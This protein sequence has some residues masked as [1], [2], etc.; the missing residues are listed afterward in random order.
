MVTK[1]DESPACIA[2]PK[3]N[4]NNAAKGQTVRNREYMELG[5]FSRQVRHWLG[6]VFVSCQDLPSV[7]H[8]FLSC[9]RDMSSA[10]AHVILGDDD[11]TLGAARQKWEQPPLFG[12]Q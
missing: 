9:F 1:L 4:K 7:S 6:V 8:D 2:F 10:Q 3:Q 5:L 12:W 11:V